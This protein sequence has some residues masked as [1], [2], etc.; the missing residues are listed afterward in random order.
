MGLNTPKFD[1]FGAEAAEE[2][3]QDWLAGQES[4]DLDY[5][6][7]L[8]T[9]HGLTLEQLVCYIDEEMEIRENLNKGPRNKF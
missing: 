3:L 8:S 1:T 7:S 6:R 9:E 2:N 5:I 4:I